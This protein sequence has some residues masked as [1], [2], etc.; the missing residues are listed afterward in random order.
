MA[1]AVLGKATTAIVIVTVA[2]VRLGFVTTVVG[3]KWRT[4]VTAGV[5]IATIEI[6]TETAVIGTA[7][8]TVVIGPVTVVTA[9]MIAVPH[10]KTSTR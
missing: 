2:P 6:G 10:Q 5:M 4:I 8:E 7:L 1:S 9:P 3:T